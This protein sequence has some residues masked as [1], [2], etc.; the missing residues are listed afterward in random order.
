MG[1]K[2][3]KHRAVRLSTRGFTLIEILIVLVIIGISVALISVNFRR[4]SK[5]ELL[6]ETRQ[7]AMLLQAIRTEAISTGKSLAWISGESGYGVFT[8]DD[9][10]RWTVVVKDLRLK[11]DALSPQVSIVDMQIAGAKVPITTPL[12]FSSS[13]FDAPF[14]LELASNEERRFINGESSGNICVPTN[15]ESRRCNEP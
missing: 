15:Q 7:L 9:K 4:D 13:G 2:E 3:N 5:A 1:E 12:V 6:D 11:D 10:R 14:Q 8:R